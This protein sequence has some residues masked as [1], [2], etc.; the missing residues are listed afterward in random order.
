MRAAT[1]V[2]VLT[3]GC[4]AG[5]HFSVATGGTVDLVARLSPDAITAFG[6]DTLVVGRYEFEGG[7]GSARVL[8]YNTRVALFAIAVDGT[9]HWSLA[10][11]VSPQIQADSDTIPRVSVHDDHG[12][13]LTRA[14][15]PATASASFDYLAATTLT[16][17]RFDA[18]GQVEATIPLEAFGV[19][20]AAAALAVLSLEDESALVVARESTALVVLRIDKS[21]QQ[22]FLRRYPNPFAGTSLGGTPIVPAA[23]TTHLYLAGSG[24]PLLPAATR[25]DGGPVAL[26]INIETGDLEAFALPQYVTGM[27]I[28]RNEIAVLADDNPYGP[29]GTH[30]TMHD[31]LNF[32]VTAAL[33]FDPSAHGVALASDGTELLLAR[34]RELRS[35]VEIDVQRFLVPRQPEQ[36]VRGRARLTGRAGATSVALAMSPE[37]FLL[38]ASIL[39][40][41]LDTGHSFHSTHGTANV[42]THEGNYHA[43]GCDHSAWQLVD[44]WLGRFARVPLSSH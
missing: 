11:P 23:T 19:E 2:L 39:E 44:G 24:Q 31:A 35:G 40:L 22:R 14:S 26:R 13:L 43:P 25:I 30:L 9:T 4:T 18:N 17:T 38:A 34:T 29:A 36:L 41:E 37:H 20:S 21:G 7:D 6:D 12:W 15:A 32:S 42:C 8:P 27:A 3:I 5:R 28:W 33:L 16:V 10:L 1:L